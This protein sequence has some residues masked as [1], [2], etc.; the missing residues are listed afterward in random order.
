M[1]FIENAWL[2]F[3]RSWAIRASLAFGVFSGVLMAL[4]AFID[5]LN[6]MLFLGLAVLFNVIII[7]LARIVKQADVEP[8]APAPGAGA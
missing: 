7:P 5:T 2:H 8:P 1:N 6:P 4:P 3:H